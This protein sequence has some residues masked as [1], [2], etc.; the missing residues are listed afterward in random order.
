MTKS[1]F[2][3]LQERCLSIVKEELRKRFEGEIFDDFLALF[4]THRTLPP[5]E[6]V[7]ETYQ[8]IIGY[9]NWLNAE[10]YERSSFLQDSLHDLAGCVNYR[11]NDGYSPRTGSYVEFYT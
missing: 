8:G 3:A 5:A 2:T 1:E 9:H 6:L 4:L 7:I 11:R 10:G